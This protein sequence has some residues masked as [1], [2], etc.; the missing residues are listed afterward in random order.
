VAAAASMYQL[1]L[2]QS[3][4]DSASFLI[5]YH[6]ICEEIP[7]SSAITECTQNALAFFSSE[8]KEVSATG[9][10]LC[11]KQKLSVVGANTLTGATPVN[12]T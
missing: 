7:S 12:F 1:L 4:H 11:I 10:N 8:Y 6:K 2:L 9:R 3:G 5:F